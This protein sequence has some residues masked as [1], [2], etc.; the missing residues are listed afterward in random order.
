MSCTML[1]IF[2]PSINPNTDGLNLDSLIMFND[3]Y[4]TGNVFID[5]PV[6]FKFF[7]HLGTGSWTS[8]RGTQ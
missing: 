5:Q 6:C 8:F 7:F 2:M 1:L 4:Y 3:D